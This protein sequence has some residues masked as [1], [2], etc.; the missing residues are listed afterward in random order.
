MHSPAPALCEPDCRAKMQQ[1]R[2]LVPLAP[3]DI[4]KNQ[5]ISELSDLYTD[6]GTYPSGLTLHEWELTNINNEPFASGGFGDCRR[7]L[8]LGCHPVVMK[9]SRD[10]YTDEQARRRADREIEVWA[11]LRHLNILPFIGSIALGS[12]PRIFLVSPFMEKGNLRQYLKKRPDVDPLS[13]LIKIAAG[14]EYLH[15]SDPPIVHGDLKA[16]NIFISST[17]EPRIGD[18][19]LSD[20]IYEDEESTSS[21]GHSSAFNFG[22]HPRWQAPEILFIDY[23]RTKR[24]DVFAFGRVIYEVYAKQVPFAAQKL[25]SV[26]AL[27]VQRGELPPRPK[28]WDCEAMWLLMAH[29]CANDPQARPSVQEIAR[30]LGY[31]ACPAVVLPRQNWKFSTQ[32]ECDYPLSR[33]NTYARMFHP[34]LEIEWRETKFERDLCFGFTLYGHE[35]IGRG[36]RRSIAKN[37]AAK[38]AFEYLERSGVISAT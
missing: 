23:R 10:Y 31:K 26:I 30:R 36:P 28:E 16:D 4:E 17:G 38:R 35:F 11:G 27:M 34:R 7:A 8:F 5:L 1:L 14:L 24:S 25:P 33:L 37:E 29:C 22:G 18:F 12:P 32:G 9:C 3:S 2:E 19:G 20:H 21:N 6:C 15:T 13:L